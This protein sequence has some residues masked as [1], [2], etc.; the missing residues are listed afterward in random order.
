MSRPMVLA[1][2]LT[3]LVL[4]VL[5]F[6]L[7]QCSLAQSP[8]NLASDVSITSITTTSAVASWTQT[9]GDF[10]NYEMTIIPSVGVIFTPASILKSSTSPSTNVTGL[11]IGNRY[12]ISV[13]TLK[14]ITNGTAKTK[15]FNTIP[16]EVNLST[17]NITSRTSTAATLNWDPVTNGTF[18]NYLL[19][20][21]PIAGGATVSPSTVP[22]GTENANLQSL[23]AGT[24][25]TIAIK[26]EYGNE[27]SAGQT[28]KLKTLPN[29]ISDANI[30]F[31]LVEADS[32]RVSWMAASG[33]FDSY[34]VKISP[35]VGGAKPENNTVQKGTESTNLVFLTAGTAY[36]VSITTS[37][38]GV[39]STPAS[40]TFWT[41]P[42][43]VTK[44]SI[45]ISNLTTTS[46]IMSWAPVTVGTFDNYTITI[47]PTSAGEEVVPNT[48]PKGIETTDLK[49]LLAGT[50]YNI[51]IKTTHK[52]K[53]SASKTVTFTTRPNPVDKTSITFSNILTVN[54]TV[55]WQAANGTFADYI[56]RISP[57]TNGAKANPAIV[58]KS[59]LSTSLTSLTAGT[60]Y[61]VG[62]IVRVGTTESTEATKVLKTR[63]DAV[64]PAT[65]KVTAV[66]ANSAVL[67]WNTVS[68]GTVDKYLIGLTPNTGGAEAFPNAV[69]VGTTTTNLVRL[70]AGTLYRS[71][72]TTQY[73]NQ[74]GV[75]TTHSFSTL[76]PNLASGVTV[77]AVT[78][79][80]A[81]AAWT[82]TDGIFDSYR[83][84]VSPD[85]DG[86]KVD[87][88][89]VTKS[90]A[91]P[92]TTL[93]NLKPRQEYT[94]R[95]STMLGNVLGAANSY[96]FTTK[97][98]PA[99][100]FREPGARN[101]TEC[102]C[103]GTCYPKAGCT[104]SACS[105][106]Y[107][108][109]PQ[110]QESCPKGLFGFGC[111]NSC[112]CKPSDICSHITGTCPNGCHPDYWGID[113]QQLLPGLN[114]AP[115]LSG[116]SCSNVTV[117][118][119][120]F[121][122]T[123]GDTSSF[124]DISRYVLQMSTNGTWSDI[125]PSYDHYSNNT[126]SHL[127]SGL[128]QHT[129]Y[130]FRVRTDANLT[131]TFPTLSYVV[132]PG[133]PS[134]VTPNIIPP[135][136]PLVTTATTTTKITTPKPTIIT[137][138]PIPGAP[139]AP[140]NLALTASSS[141]TIDVSWEP[142]A[143][144]DHT[145][146]NLFY[147]LKVPGD[148]P[149]VAP[150]DYTETEVPLAASIKTHQ[151]SGLKP[152]SSYKISLRATNLI[153]SGQAAVAT[154][155]TKEAAPTGK[156]SNLQASDV[157]ASSFMLS[158]VPPP[159]HTKNGAFSMYRVRTQDLAGKSN[160]YEYKLLNAS[161][162][163][164]GL[165]PGTSYQVVVAFLNAETQPSPESDAVKVNMSSWTIIV[166]AKPGFVELKW[167]PLYPRSN[168]VLGDYKVTYWE[169]KVNSE[170]NF[171]TAS[172]TSYNASGLTNGVF[173]FQ[174]SVQSTLSWTSGLNSEIATVDTRKTVPSQPTSLSLANNTESGIQIIWRAPISS[175]S[176]VTH[177]KVDYKFTITGIPSGVSALRYTMGSETVTA[178][179]QGG[180]TLSPLD[181]ATTYRISVS[182]NNMYGFG[183]PSVQAFSTRPGTPVKPA[184]PNVAESSTT[185]ITLTLTLPTSTKGPISKMSVIVVKNTSAK[186]KR[187]AVAAL[188]T[189]TAAVELVP[190][191]YTDAGNT[192]TVVLGNGKSGSTNAPLE[193]GTKYDLCY[194]VISTY[195]G[196][197]TI[198]GIIFSADTKAGTNVTM[199]IIIVVVVLLV[200][201]IIIVIVVVVLIWKRKRESM[202]KSL[203]R[204]TD[205]MNMNQFDDTMY[206]I[207][208]YGRWSDVHKVG[209]PRSI[210]LVKDPL[211]ADPNIIPIDV[212]YHK[213]PQEIMYTSD[214]AMAPE[215]K[216]RNRFEAFLPYDHSRVVLQPGKNDYINANYIDGYKKPRAYIAAQSP[217][218]GETVA[219]FW[220][221]V[222]QENTLQIVMLTLPVEDGVFKCEQYW[223]D[224]THTYGDIKVKLLSTEKY[225]YFCIRTF[226][227][228]PNPHTKKTITQCH[229][230]GWPCHG[231]PEDTIPFLDF[232]YK[233]RS[234]SQPGAGPVV[235]HCGTGVSRTSVF[236]AVNSLIKAGRKRGQVNV[237]DFCSEMRQ[238][239]FGMVRTLKQYL[240]I[241]DM[242]YEALLTPD[243]ILDIDMRSG[244]HALISKNPA[245]GHTNLYE[246]FKIFR[247]FTPLVDE[248][249]CRRGLD[250]ANKRKNRFPNIVPLD[251]FR[252]KLKTPGGHGRTDYINA[253][254]LDSY[255]RKD[256]FIVT[257]TP[258]A[259]TV[260]DFWK[261]VYDYKISTIVMLHDR[262][263]KE[264]SSAEYWPKTLGSVR[265]DP[266]VV[267]LRTFVKE[268]DYVISRTMDVNNQIRPSEKAHE[269]KQFHL[270]GDWMMYD[271]VPK[272]RECVLQLI[273]AVFEN[274]KKTA[275]HPETPIL[276]HC[277]DG[278][279][280]SGLFCCLMNL[281][282]RMQI[283]RY[284]DIFHCMKHLKRRRSQFVDDLDQYRFC[285]KAL[286]DFINTRM[287]NIPAS[288]LRKNT[289]NSMNGTT[290]GTN[291][292]RQNK[293]HLELTLAANDLHDYDYTLS[294]A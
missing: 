19:S 9:V 227:V 222:C 258:L 266:F 262:T 281:V 289:K 72:I 139:S 274:R 125:K 123:R 52:G 92:Q 260:V 85:V 77:S 154:I 121:D 244:Y 221:M 259:E 12:T 233:F 290:N 81:T 2:A 174:V 73:G 265:Y 286:W 110:C 294:V 24:E 146:Y 191:A 164:T 282:E 8:P 45:I 140:L 114:Q 3:V 11:T 240:L 118:W 267:T 152:W 78:T 151:L 189:N 292:K 61:T 96:T 51:T 119:L 165:N 4:G 108:T 183:D 170:K 83:T 41:K 117:K 246:Q 288:I 18:D 247:D 89:N 34:I 180:V 257:Q 130:K 241:Y 192:T 179:G 272:S 276:V 127:V 220:R 64:A 228:V 176:P 56:V 200:I 63:P 235:V 184:M 287:I 202:S 126:Y 115:T 53:E 150:A 107:K 28:Y 57:S 103:I 17:V 275:D 193:A 215:N 131:I 14:G 190:S 15:T 234:L 95:V 44:D 75:A 62:I 102:H 79:T 203:W 242:L 40:K 264:E 124:P 120:A 237:F 256:A 16:S 214:H 94:V 197:S 134:P 270:D 31:S 198:A 239:R 163:I 29:A 280:R 169:N 261:L 243:S 109:P 148:C 1:P 216:H 132:I 144:N 104:D 25:Y 205:T 249:K 112:H 100:N 168:E 47:S 172:Q 187:R 43:F 98:C 38:G 99:G 54:A 226:E 50:A 129:S 185:S 213:L 225:A 159:C 105:K 291:E 26:T 22:R 229:F 252:P 116:V 156:C 219:D 36:D 223:P 7:P 141:T 70:T 209:E 147:G 142:P 210:E 6:G 76:P 145:G 133:R 5:S 88:P 166:T 255:T 49:K 177:Y 21:S 271:H 175:A 254:I 149:A 68:S 158:F 39:E 161:Y 157:T 58:A 206:N 273:D 285:Y 86:E 212:E 82:K 253:L 106:G 207:R 194:K 231:I 32:A 74:T 230:T 111:Q 113:C 278:A 55:T 196:E 195:G 269:V 137:T 160:S 30:V 178:T 20:I 143:S 90:E 66:T 217:F 93:S 153:G 71:A 238:N 284:A 69:N 33:S 23:T 208:P 13:R 10:D 87:T 67:S 37:A 84:T 251:E 65:I 135:C 27:T 162:A 245:T 181:P 268:R 42:A 101:C 204:S 199:I 293:R 128:Q 279:E 250:P 122:T 59:T 167:Q 48:V 80:T 91:N 182:A 224:S 46:A 60:A 211:D 236:I 173:N 201:I 97:D 283:D 35:T 136:F 248:S 186:R 218:N 232:I 171:E 138:S 263:Y 155:R 277:I 188:C